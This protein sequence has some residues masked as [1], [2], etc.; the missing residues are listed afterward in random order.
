[1]QTDKMSVIINLIGFCFFILAIPILLANLVQNNG[2]IL[3]KTWFWTIVYCITVLGFWPIQFGYHWVIRNDQE[4]KIFQRVDRFSLLLLIA[5]MFTPCLMRFVS[6]L[7]SSI[8]IVI[9]WVV[10]GLGAILLWRW[11]ELPRALVP[12]LAFTIGLLCIFLLFSSLGTLNLAAKNFLGWGSAF[13]IMGGIIYVL[14]KPN[15][16]PDR[17]GF[18]E[19]FHLCIMIGVIILH[20]LVQIAI[21]P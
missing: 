2:I 18:H 1:M 21:F 11:K 5:S 15:L 6:P 16:I 7:V 20:E 13:V 10:V 14:K 8:L 3:T 17:F 19:V 9:I 4:H 12:I